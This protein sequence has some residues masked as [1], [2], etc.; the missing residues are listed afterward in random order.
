MTSSQKFVLGLTGIVALVALAVIGM[1]QHAPEA[2]DVPKYHRDTALACVAGDYSVDRMPDTDPAG[3]VAAHYPE[4]LRA[5]RMEGSV[6][7]RFVVDTA[8]RAE[9]KLVQVV[10]SDH[11]YFTVAAE[12]ALGRMHFLPA[13]KDGKPKRCWT[14]QRFDFELTR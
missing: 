9:M 2:L 8:G 1:R 11:R 14:E 6:T 3:R 5:L 10:R 13:M 12:S 4:S 7:L